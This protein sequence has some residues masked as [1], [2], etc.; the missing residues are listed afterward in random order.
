MARLKLERL[1]LR[2]YSK[3]LIVVLFLV[4]LYLS[5]Q[6]TKPYLVALF[7]GILLTF[8]FYPLYK[9]VRRVIRNNN[10]AA[11]VTSLLIIL[12][13]SIPMIIIANVLINQ[14]TY[15]HDLF[16][17]SDS[18][19][20]II[21]NYVS[22]ELAPRIENMILGS[23][24]FI[25]ET[26]YSFILSLPQKIINFFII[27]FVMFYLFKDGNKIVAYFKKILPFKKKEEDMIIKQVND[28][29]YAILYG[30]VLISILQGVIATIGF[31]IFDV[32]LPVLWGAITAIVSMLPY[33]GPG[34]VWVPIVV[35]KYINGDV[36]NAIGL[37]IFSLILITVILDWLIKPKLI[38]DRANVHPIIILLGILGGISFFGI[39]GFLMGPIILALL[40]LFIQVYLKRK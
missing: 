2:D 10:V 30:T 8:L 38:A 11:A 37:T 35:F 5:F 21:S 6:I 25:K 39:F 9:L 36:N 32:P 7:A 28:T 23:I 19:K 4:I 17:K 22:P 31:Y 34:I 16:V 29:F 26:S 18:V 40:V 12:A 20:T 3:Y 1:T 15:L 13:V 27:L 33:I 14:S 24:Q